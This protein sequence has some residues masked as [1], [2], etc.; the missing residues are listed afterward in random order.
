MVSDNTKSVDIKRKSVS[1]DNLSIS[2]RA[3]TSVGEKQS[4]GRRSGPVRGSADSPARSRSLSS[5]SDRSPRK[6]KAVSRK[7]PAKSEKRSS[8]KNKSHKQITKSRNK[9]PKKLKKKRGDMKKKSRDTSSSLKEK[10]GSKGSD[11]PRSDLPR[12]YGSESPKDRKEK[13]STGKK[14]SPLKA[15]KMEPGYVCGRASRSSISGWFWDR[16]QPSTSYLQV[17]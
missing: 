14:L 9:T 7:E 3:S 12:S 16:S 5:V 1:H 8:K 10:S 15:I 6:G 17:S 4:Q 2:D 11:L 13:P